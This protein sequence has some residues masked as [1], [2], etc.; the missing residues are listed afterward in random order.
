[1][2]DIISKRIKE[3][4]ENQDMT[5]K[6]LAQKLNRNRETIN[7]WENS[8]RDLKTE[9]I[10]ALAKIFDVSTDYLL[11]LSDLPLTSIKRECFEGIIED[12]DEIDSNNNIE[13][14]NHYAEGR[15]HEPI[16]AI[17]DWQLNFCLGNVVKY[18]S[19]AG[20]KDNTIEDLEKAKFY[21]EYEIK[22]RKEG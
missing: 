6:E 11:G 9:D 18:I 10:A 20:R 19:R 15:Q 22:K 17:N 1:M 7:Q 4:R 21:L 14:P 3:Q 8:A 2:I 16:D 13:H 12:I 5:Q